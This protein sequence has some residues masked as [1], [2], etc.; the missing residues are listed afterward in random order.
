[1]IFGSPICKI[2]TTHQLIASWY[3]NIAMKNHGPFI[4]GLPIKTSIY[5]GFSMAMSYNQRV[6][7]KKKHKQSLCSK[8]GGIVHRS[9]MDTSNGRSITPLYGDEHAF[10]NDISWFTR[11][12]SK[13]HGLQSF[14]WIKD[15]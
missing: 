6:Y 15:S 9:I 8:T 5:E 11:A 3:F 12:P 2:N 10:T 4:D 7:F 1:M 14:L 13:N